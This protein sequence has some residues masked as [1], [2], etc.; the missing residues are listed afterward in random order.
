MKNKKYNLK[1]FEDISELHNFLIKA[2]EFVKQH[3][4]IY[5]TKV[6]HSLS[7]I[8]RVASLCSELA[9]QLD[10]ALDVLL[11]AALFHD[12]GRPMEEIT[13]KCH[14]ELS[15]EIAKEYLERQSRN[16][17]IPEVCTAISSHRFSKN[18]E[19]TTKESKILKDADGLDALGVIGVYRTIS[20]STEKGLN[21]E[22]ARKHFDDKLLKLSSLMHFPLTKKI[23]EEESKILK[24]FAEEMDVS[25]NRS[26]LGFLLD[27][28]I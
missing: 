13:G 28:L 16:E 18:I 23:A 11:V 9:P 24:K 26:K 17:L 6:S 15:S 5:E 22:E 2:Y 1:Y 7:H 21:L 20:Y 14:A 25:I 27:N 3:F 10:A 4:L 19:A 8:I 12:V